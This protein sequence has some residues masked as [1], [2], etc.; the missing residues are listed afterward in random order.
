MKRIV[1]YGATVALVVLPSIAYSN[2]G[3]SSCAVGG[4]GT[5]GLSSGGKAQGFREEAGSFTNSGN[6]DAGRLTIQGGSGTVSGT[7]RD[8]VFRGLGTGL[9]GDWSGQCDEEDFPGD[10]PP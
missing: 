5:G 2:C 10:C 7:L 6:A 3:G 1:L 8:E 9:L 4:S